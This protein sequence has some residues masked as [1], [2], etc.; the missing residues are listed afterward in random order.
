MDL[1]RRQAANP[2]LDRSAALREAMVEMIEKGECVDEVSKQPI[3]AYAHPM[4]W[5]PFVLIGEGGGARN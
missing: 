4:F 5:S 3:F 2:Q 1:F